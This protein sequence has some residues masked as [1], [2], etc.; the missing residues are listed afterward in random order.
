MV[1][2]DLQRAC[3][4]LVDVD[5]AC[6]EDSLDDRVIVAFLEVCL[7][8]RLYLGW[9]ITAGDVTEDID[10]GGAGAAIRMRGY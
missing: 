8:R 4:R 9:V 3:W 7:Q 5:V 2:E 10:I 6:W 1:L